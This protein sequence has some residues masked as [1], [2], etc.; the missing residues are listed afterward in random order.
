MPKREGQ[1]ERVS[2]EVRKLAL[3]ARTSTGDS[4]IE[5]ARRRP[6]MLFFMRHDGC[7]FCR[8][9]LARIAKLRDQIESRGTGLVL[10]HMSSG[11]HAHHLLAR[12][13]LEDVPAISDPRR[14]LYRAFGLRRGS[15]RQVAGPAL[16]PQGVRLVLRRGQSLSRKGGDLFQL[17]GLFLVFQGQVVRS[18]FHRNAGEMPDF[19]SF[20]VL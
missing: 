8:E 13:G 17:S 7:P 5:L 4:V 12:F 6:I 14:S 18:F 20:A 10:V 1:Y 16:W 9:S 15:L 19:L 2:E 3:K 11:D